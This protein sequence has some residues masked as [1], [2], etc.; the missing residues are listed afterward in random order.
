M[1]DYYECI[2]NRTNLFCTASLKLVPI[3]NGSK[4]LEELNV[5]I[6]ENICMIYL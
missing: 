3:N 4:M 2:K 5:S 1:D 6:F